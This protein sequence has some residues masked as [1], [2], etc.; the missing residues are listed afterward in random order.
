VLPNTKA[1]I[2]KFPQSVFFPGIKRANGRDEDDAKR[3][4]IESTASYIKSPSF[5][6][7]DSGAADDPVPPKYKPTPVFF[8]MLCNPKAPLAGCKVKLLIS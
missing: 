7:S 4:E 6:P 1:R 5:S 2:S 8:A 3:E